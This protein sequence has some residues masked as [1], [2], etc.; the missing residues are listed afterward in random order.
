MH[1]SLRRL[2]F[3]LSKPR[4]FVS[5]Q[6]ERKGPND[7][8]YTFRPF[9]EH[10]CIFV[11]I[12]KCAGVS[13]CTSLFGN[14]AGGHTTLRM[15]Q[16]VFSP[17][18]YTEYFKFSIVRNPWDRLVSAYQFLKNDGM[19]DDDRTWAEQHLSGY[20]DFDTFVQ[21]WLNETNVRK[22]IHFLPQSEFI[23]N[24]RNQAD[25]DFIGYFENLDSDFAHIC[26]R[27]GVTASLPRL[28]NTRS[29]GKDFRTYYTD[30]TRRIVA[31]VYAEDISM[32]GYSFDNSSLAA[33]LAQRHSK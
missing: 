16:I 27:L 17:R 31:E 11:H 7:E 20:P 22:G 23:T 33:Q 30:K 5:L 14:L 6:R 15:Y 21:G 2:G 28:N 12:P 8:G 19:N 4:D 13:V 29:R 18:E 26:A 10:R 1:A 3:L 9:D 24:C 32:L 25:L